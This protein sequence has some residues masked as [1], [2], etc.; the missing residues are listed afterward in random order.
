MKSNAGVGCESRGG[1][2]VD[3]EST[4]TE[5]AWC[6]DVLETRF[7]NRHHRQL[8]P[9]MHEEHAKPAATNRSDEDRDDDT[10]GGAGHRA[11]QHPN[12]DGPGHLR[13]WWC[14]L[15]GNWW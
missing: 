14:T 7:M 3:L 9:G 5:T 8:R 11:Q 10:D 2:C 1:S 12:D 6:G 13:G 15:N 4:E